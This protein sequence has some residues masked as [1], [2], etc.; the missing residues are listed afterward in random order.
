VSNLLLT[1][2]LY[3][4]PA[5]PELVPRP[6]LIE[7]LNAGL[8]RKF[9]LISAPVGFGKTWRNPA[10]RLARGPSTRLTATSPATST[11]GGRTGSRAFCGAAGGCERITL[12]TDGPRSPRGALKRPAD[13]QN[14]LKTGCSSAFL[15]HFVVSADDFNHRRGGFVCAR[16]AVEYN[17]GK[18]SF[19]H[20]RC[21]AAQS[22][23]ISTA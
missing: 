23:R 19:P 17:M 21:S 15:T 8:H 9:T 7:R 18:P 12:G 5:Q 2:K 3:I 14:L 13:T 16:A 20:I 4:P 22:S 6:R 11:R 1:T 10:V